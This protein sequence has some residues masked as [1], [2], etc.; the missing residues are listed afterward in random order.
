MIIS[1]SAS[2]SLTAKKEILTAKTNSV[3][4]FPPFMFYAL[5]LNLNLDKA[6]RNIPLSNE[7]KQLLKRYEVS[8]VG[9]MA[10]R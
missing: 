10:C 6:L 7:M 8:E 4:L 5:L 3:K 9:T 1:L 2:V